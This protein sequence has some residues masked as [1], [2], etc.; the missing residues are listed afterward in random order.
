MPGPLHVDAGTQTLHNDRR[1]RQAR[2]RKARRVAF[3]G[4]VALLATAVAVSLAYAGSVGSLA[5]GVR[6]AGIDVGGES[7]DDAVRALQRRSAAVIDRPVVFLAG[8]QRFEFTARQLGVTVDWRAAVDDARRDG[9][10]FGPLRGFRRLVLRL[11]GQD[12]SPPVSAY[13]AAVASAVSALAANVDRPQV[14]AAIV[15]KGLEPSIIPGR[16]GRMLDQAAAR[17]V[18]LSALASFERGRTVVLPQRRQNVRVTTA[19]LT[20]VLERLRTMLSGPVQLRYGSAYTAVTPRQLAAMIEVP[21]PGSRAL[22][23]GGPAAE[24]ILDRLTKLVDR[25]PTSATFSLGADGLPVVVPA[26]PGLTLDRAATG[27]SLLRAAASPTERVG[28]LVVATATPSRTTAE[29][30]AMG[31]KEIVGSYETTYGG[32]AN[33]LHN[34]RLVAGLVDDHYIAPGATFSFNRTTGE[35]SAKRGFLEAPVIINGELQNGIGGGVCQVSTT[36]FNAAFEAGLPITERTNHALYISH[37]PLGRDA[38]VDYPGTDL[39]FR[40]DTRHWI[41][42]RAF[43]GSSSLRVT[44][45]GTSPGRRVESSTTPLRA[46]GAVPVRRVPDPTLLKGETVVDTSVPSSPPLATS[47]HRVV[48]DAKGKVLYD[49]T[50]YSSYRGQPRVVHVGTKPKPKPVN[51]AAA[52]KAGKII[53]LH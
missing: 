48:Y 51:K 5:G 41:W 23:V 36:V 27:R 50:W 18:L 28:E 16:P 42:L 1:Q 45:F 2:L 8:D 13:E 40:N 32:I 26:V 17:E 24:R 19:S 52:D 44:L 10:G 20:P 37:Y 43:I 6:I 49:S 38:T 3:A 47:V 39:Q 53:A 30:T 4:V 11:S 33:R 31:I 35:R 14:P 22:Q 21:E 9:G 12:I 7:A 25:P 29:A 34:V 46:V 15:L